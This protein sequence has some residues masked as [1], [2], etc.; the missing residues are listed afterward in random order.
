VQP[1]DIFAWNPSH[2]QFYLDHQLSG[3]EFESIAE[4]SAP[5]ALKEMFCFPACRDSDDGKKSPIGYLRG[6][7]GVH[8]F[9][10]EGEIYLAVAQS[11]CDDFMTARQCADFAAQPQSA[12][13]QYNRV[14]KRFA[15]LSV[16]TDVEVKELC[17]CVYAFP[18]VCLRSLDAFTCTYQAVGTQPCLYILCTESFGACTQV[19]SHG[20]H[21]DFQVRIQVRIQV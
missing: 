6:A 19:R 1:L 11:V 8:S 10:S 4:E 20:K 3:P 15:E 7:T 18:W 12:V 5:T 16:L 2:Q 17:V 14:T 21:S 13:L 9:E